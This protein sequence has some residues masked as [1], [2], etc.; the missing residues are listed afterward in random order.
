ML[1]RCDFIFIT[2]SSVDAEASNNGCGFTLVKIHHFYA[3]VWFSL[4]D[5]H[6]L[7]WN[8][9]DYIVNVIKVIKQNNQ[10]KT[11]P[12][13]NPQFAWIFARFFLSGLP[14]MW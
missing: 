11:L 3:T 6:I 4:Y 2:C 12:R 8:I 9:Q 14:G 7:A 5:F 10:K 13:A 1:L